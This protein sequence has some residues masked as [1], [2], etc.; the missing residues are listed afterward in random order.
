[1][2]HTMWSTPDAPHHDRAAPHAT[3]Y[4]TEQ[5]V[6]WERSSARRARLPSDWRTVRVP[7][8]LDRDGHTCQLGYPDLCIGHADQVD[9]IRPGDDHTYDNLQAVC[10]PCHAH[11]SALE[12]VAARATIRA[13]SRLPQESHPG[14]ARPPGDHPPPT[15]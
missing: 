10:E 2:H 12:G 4:H 1:M 15:P 14:H 8:V 3:L 9:H 7:H 6:T 5:R 13:G 11:K